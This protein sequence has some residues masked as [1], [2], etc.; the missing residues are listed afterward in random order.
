MLTIVNLTTLLIYNP[1]NRESSSPHVCCLL[2]ILFDS[3][4]YTIYVLY[5]AEVK[6]DGPLSLLGFNMEKICFI[7]RL[8][9]TFTLYLYVYLGNMYAIFSGPLTCTLHNSNFN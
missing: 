1:A 5:N 3:N 4:I 6:M 9:Y 8:I 7:I 2:F